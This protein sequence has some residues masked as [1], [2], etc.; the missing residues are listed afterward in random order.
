M[1]VILSGVD[2]RNQT[3][4]DALIIRNQF[5]AVVAKRRKPAELFDQHRGLTKIIREP[6]L[7]A[8]SGVRN[9]FRGR[10]KECS[11]PGQPPTPPPR[12]SG[13][14]DQRVQ[15]HPRDG[16]EEHQQQPCSRGFRSSAKRHEG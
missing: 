11:G 6:G 10:F 2:I 12:V 14:A 13:A 1:D 8:V 15:E 9:L 5:G 3:G 4:D 7:A 16:Q